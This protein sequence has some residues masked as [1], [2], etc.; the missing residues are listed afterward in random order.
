MYS[1]GLQ[2]R[3][4]SSCDFL[5][6]E[7]VI[8]LLKGQT[9]SSGSTNRF[10]FQQPV[11]AVWDEVDHKCWYIGF[12]TSES[13]E[14]VVIDYLER[15]S[16]DCDNTWQRPLVDNT[17]TTSLVQIIPCPVEGEW[18]F[19]NRIPHFIIKNSNDIAQKFIENW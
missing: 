6:K 15:A 9:T 17:Q 16:R 19:T 4:P 1:H 14:S 8:G 7:E 13:S 5:S 18:S 10:V 12:I 11:A 2:Y 3:A